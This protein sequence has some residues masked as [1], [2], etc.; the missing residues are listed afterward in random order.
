MNG[1][2][3]EMKKILSLFVYLLLLFVLRAAP[4]DAAAPASLS[5]PLPDGVQKTVALTFDDGPKRATTE[6]L[7]DGLR[8]REFS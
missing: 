2:N 8:E 6:T 5:A 3:A 7:L 4:E 1:G